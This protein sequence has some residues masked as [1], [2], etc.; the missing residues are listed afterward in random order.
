[1]PS[2]HRRSLLARLGECV[3]GVGGHEAKLSHDHHDHVST[4]S[5]D[6]RDSGYRDFGAYPTDSV[7]DLNN[8]LLEVRLLISTATRVRL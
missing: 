6:A 1:M 5:V 8:R 3:A 4:G 2:P 7:S